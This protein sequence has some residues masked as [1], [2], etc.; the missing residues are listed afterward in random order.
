[1]SYKEFID[2]ILTTRGRFACGDEYKERHHIVPRCM[3]GT[4]DKD[5]LI[6]LY[7]RE[8]FEA[9]RLLALENP[10]E[11]GLTYAWWCMCQCKGSSKK[12]YI[13]TSEEYEEAKI[14]RVKLI[15]GENHPLYGKQLSEETREK[16]SKAHKGKKLSD[17]ARR[18][19]SLGHIGIFSGENHPMYGKHHTEETKQKLRERMSGK[20]NPNYGK[21]MSE[22]QKQKISQT[23]KDKYQKEKHPMYGKHHTEET[24][25][26]ISESHKGLQIG[27]N[28]P[29]AKPIIQLD[30]TNN[31]IKIWD[32]IKLASNEL[33]IHRTDISSCCSGRLKT[34]GG[35]HWKYLYDQT[36]KDG[37]VIQGA[38][39]LG[40]ITE[41]EALRMLKE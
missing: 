16:I 3:G 39:S 18:A 23:K 28:N 11:S 34:A 31:L 20:N 36:K 27:V 17:F 29:H 5:N 38:I 12:R 32:Y 22:E 4:D 30:K 37:T 41:E 10:N 6:D 35:Y 7:A 9:H 15:S 33:G 26:K 25:Q 24:K 13:V 19:I 1:M 40:L 8:H 21:P 14:S 2:N